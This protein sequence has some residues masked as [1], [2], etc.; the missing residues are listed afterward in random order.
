MKITMDKKWAQRQDP[1]KEVRVLCVDS[2][3]S[4]TPVVYVNGGGFIFATAPEGYYL[5]RDREHLN[6]LVPL[7]EKVADV[8][9]VVR[10]DGTRLSGVFDSEDSANRVIHNYGVEVHK[11]YRVVRMTQ[12]EEKI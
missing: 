9:L 4:K 1:T 8:W 6:D 3:H 5:G 10:N 2:G 7:Q 11:P 12:A